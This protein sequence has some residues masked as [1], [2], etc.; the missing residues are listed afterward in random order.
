MGFYSLKNYLINA[1]KDGGINT[2]EENNRDITYKQKSKYIASFGKDNNFNF[3]WI[4]YNNVNDFVI[5]SHTYYSPII[6]DLFNIKIET[7]SNSPLIFF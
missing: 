1:S 4:N 7:F 6:H 3:Y 2:K 5:G